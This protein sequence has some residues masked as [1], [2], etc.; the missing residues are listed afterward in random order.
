MR[1]ATCVLVA[2]VCS[3]ASA[4]EPGQPREDPI[5]S[6]KQVLERAKQTLEDAKRFE[7]E[8]KQRAKGEEERMF[9]QAYSLWKDVKCVQVDT[10]EVTGSDEVRKVLPSAR[11]RA[12]IVLRLARDL[13]F[14]P[15]CQ[16][17]PDS[18]PKGT[19]AN[20][21]L[22]VDTVGT[23]YPVAYTAKLEAV[24]LFGAMVQTNCIQEWSWRSA[25]WQHGPQLGF[26]YRVNL[27]EVI[28]SVVEQETE[29]LGTFMARVR[30][31]DF[32]AADS[33]TPKRK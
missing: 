7:Q 24:I 11:L 22:S 31:T 17:D 29:T 13:P 25:D 20:V 30:S 14:L 8:Y 15:V 21:S 12:V 33:S 6:T 2:L 28:N 19:V 16:S 23:D 5:E 32:G 4:S 26:G 10:P 9:T 1:F 27:P 18:L 3:C